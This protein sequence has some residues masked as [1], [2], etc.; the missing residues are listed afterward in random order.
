[1]KDEIV[2]RLLQLNADFYAHFARPFAESRASPQPGFKLLLEYLPDNYEGVLD[3]G[4]GNGRFGQFLL[5]AGE[6]FEYTGIDFTEDLLLIAQQRVSGDYYSRDIS[7]SGFLAG[8]HRFELIVC[9][10]TMQHVPG[11]SNRMAM[12]AEMQAHLADDGRIFLSNW[13][14]LDSPRQRR[15]I[16]DWAVIGLNEDVV[17]PGDYLLSWQRDGKGLRYV[18]AIDLEETLRLAEGADLQVVSHFRS[19][20]REGNLNLYTVLAPL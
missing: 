8:I 9:L 13:Q 20:G 1:M 15:K 4:C 17:E 2:R 12:L 6:A 11:H 16:Q 18:C 7:R 19:D 10:A 3:V 5:N 14:F